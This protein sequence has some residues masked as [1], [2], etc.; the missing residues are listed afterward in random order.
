MISTDKA[1]LLSAAR[2]AAGVYVTTQASGEHDTPER[3]LFDAGKQTPKEMIDAYANKMATFDTLPLDVEGAVSRLYR[4][5][6]SIFSGYTGTGKTTYLRQLVCHLL[7]LGKSVFVATLEQDPEDYLIELASTA[8]G[9]DMVNE[10]Q[11]TSFLATYGE[12]LKLWGIIGVSEHK[13]ILATIRE[14]S[15]TTP[16]LDYAIIDS[17]MMLDVDE[18]DI[19]D[20][21][22]CAALL[23]ATTITSKVHIFLVAHPK[24]PLDPEASPSV[25]DVSGTAKLTNLAFN[26]YFIRRGP[27][28]PGLQGITAMELHILKQ[29]TRGTIGML[30]GYFYTNHRQFHL[31]ANAQQPNFY[32]PPENYPASGLTEEI[33]EHILNKNA[34]RVDREAPSTQPWEIG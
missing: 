22:K 32:L 10:K 30:N 28:Q 19:E 27:N 33:P 20:Q 24:K 9:V 7:K 3:I 17:F 13:K 1:D 2:K 5:Q 21:R 6:W 12:R 18:S 26:V 15:A 16:G 25:H 23:T 31:D 4:G 8:A 11:L 29:R 34:F 14:L